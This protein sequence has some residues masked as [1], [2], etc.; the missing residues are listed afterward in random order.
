MPKFRVKY[1]YED[2]FERRRVLPG[3]II[4]LPLGRV[5]R[6]QFLGV[7]GE[8]IRDEPTERATTGAPE[9]AVKRGVA[10][11]RTKADHGTDE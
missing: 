4:D 10:N 9:K 3:E 1:E 5:E 6:L 2:L 11:G 7:L 8:L